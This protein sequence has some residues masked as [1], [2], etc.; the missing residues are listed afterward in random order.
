[1]GR[2]HHLGEL[3]HRIM[4]VLWDAREATVSEVHA[5]LGAEAAEDERALTTIATMLSKMERKGVVGHRVEGRQFVYRPLVSER[6]VART[7]VADLVDQLFEGSASAMISHL[8]TEQEIDAAELDR[9]TR[10][11]ADR[12]RKE[13]RRGRR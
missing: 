7:M 2:A 6:D 10:M 5:R 4:R 3:Q 8:L 13:G 12:E 9:L 1:M 11:I